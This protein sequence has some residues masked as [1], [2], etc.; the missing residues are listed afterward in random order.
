MFEMDGLDGPTM[1]LALKSA[2]YK[3]PV[4]CKVVSKLKK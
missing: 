3:L 1:T 4:K 2:G